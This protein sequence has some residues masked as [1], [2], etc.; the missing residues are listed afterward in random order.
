MVEIR[1]RN[2]SNIEVSDSDL[3]D[4]FSIEKLAQ[5]IR[6]AKAENG[7]ATSNVEISL[8]NGGISLDISNAK[9]LSVSSISEK[10]QEISRLVDLI[11]R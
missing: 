1:L 7:T 8:T 2:Y 10:I 3:F 5:F 4:Y 9:S 11:K 6:A